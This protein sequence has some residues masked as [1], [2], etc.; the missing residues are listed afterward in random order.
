MSLGDQ[1]GALFLDELKEV[2][3][4]ATEDV[5]RFGMKIGSIAAAAALTGDEKLMAQAKDQ[6]KVLAEVS[7]I[8][9]KQAEWSFVEKLFTVVVRSTAVGLGL[10]K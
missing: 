6:I 1:L 8:R 9:L 3:Q 10:L 5:K 2:L 4:G 7:R